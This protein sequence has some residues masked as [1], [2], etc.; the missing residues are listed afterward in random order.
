M[1]TAGSP[2]HFIVL[3]IVVVGIIGF[4][5]ARLFKR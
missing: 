5:A 1:H 4:L 3:G 2:L